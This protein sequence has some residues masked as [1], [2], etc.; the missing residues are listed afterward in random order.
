VLELL[1]GGGEN[2]AGAA[3][4][5]QHP[6][7]RF[8]ERLD[9]GADRRL[10]DIEVFGGILCETTITRLEDDRFFLCSA[11]AAEWH[12]HQWMRQHLP[13]DGG[14]NIANVTARFGT[15]ILAGPK[16]RDVLG[17][18]TSAD[19]SSDAFPWLSA[20][21]IE[22]GFSSM[23]AMRINYVG[24]LGWELHIPVENMIAVYEAL[25]DAVAEHDIADFGMYAMESLR[26][27]K[28]YR[29]WKVDLTQEHT[30]LEAS[31]DRFVRL[32]KTDFIGREALLEQQQA[33]LT[34]RLVP[35]IVDADDADAPACAGVF[36]NGDRV[37]LVTSGGYGHSLQQS[38]ALAYVRPDLTEPGTALEV[39]ILGQRR[40]AVVGTEPLYDPDNAR[41][42]A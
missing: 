30:P 25:M 15:L 41:L 20:Q 16:A 14:V 3:A 23:L 8:L 11:G 2:G 22:I 40:P 9:A 4:R 38:I 5:E 29:S 1:A 42:R 32:N 21:A 34:Q 26:L 24:E 31:L 10:G 37:G 27:E 6:V 36:H 13:D 12:D 35:L 7:K 18:I 33:G 39:E 28:C 17:R 19:L